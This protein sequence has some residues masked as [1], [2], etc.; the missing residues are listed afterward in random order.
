MQM[1]LAARAGGMGIAAHGSF[2]GSHH[3]HSPFLSPDK[4]NARLT[5]YYGL[6]SMCLLAESRLVFFWR[7]SERV[8][9]GRAAARGRTAGIKNGVMKDA[10][11]LMTR[12]E[13]RSALNKGV[14]R[15]SYCGSWFGASSA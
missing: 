10:V 2:V 8:T 12:R 4:E 7:C 15:G 9:S 1:I 6:A 14:W 3:H 11:R 5:A 13:G